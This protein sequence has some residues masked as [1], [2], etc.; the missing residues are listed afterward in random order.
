MAEYKPGAR[1]QPDNEFRFSFNRAASWSD[2]L[3]ARKRAR[4]RSAH[5]CPIFESNCP[6][7]TQQYG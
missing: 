1:G 2:E 5:A 3:N 6:N 4:V 7:R